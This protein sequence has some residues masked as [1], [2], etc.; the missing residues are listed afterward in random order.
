MEKIFFG[1]FATLASLFIIWILGWFITLDYVW[2]ISTII[3]RLI[4]A[5]LFI[6]IVAAQIKVLRE[7]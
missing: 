6:M 2:V 7:Y 5:V 3:G 1:T 4:F